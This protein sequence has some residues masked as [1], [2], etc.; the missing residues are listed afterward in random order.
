[1]KS[2]VIRFVF[3]VKGRAL[4]TLHLKVVVDEQALGQ[5]VK[6]VHLTEHAKDLPTEVQEPKLERC[7][8]FEPF[9]LWIVCDYLSY[10]VCLGLVVSN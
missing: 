4:H 2:S 9:L 8:L 3:F 10:L 6:P 5:M 1:M 7:S